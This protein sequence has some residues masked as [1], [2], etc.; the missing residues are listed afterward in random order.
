MKRIVFL[1]HWSK[2]RGGAEYSLLDI[3]AAMQG[4]AELFLIT[5]EEGGVTDKAR[6]LS[7]ECY[8]IPCRLSQTAIQREHILRHSIQSVFQLV[9]FLA[10]IMKVYRRVKKIDPDII[11]ANVPKSHITLFALQKMGISCTAVFH[12]REIFKQSSLPFRLYSLLFRKNQS[13][14]I[15]ISQAV[16]NHLPLRLKECADV[17]YN[18][19]FVPQRIRQVSKQHST[20]LLYLGRIVP[21]KG[22][23]L[24][25]DVCRL[26]R[27][28]FPHHSITM[29]LVGDTLYWTQKY[30]DH[31]Q[32]KIVEYN[33]T[34]I[35]AL[36]PHTET[37]ESVFR[38]H[39]LFTIASHEEPFGRVVA[40]AQAFGLPVVAFDSGGIAEIVAH[41][42]S[43]YCIPYGDTSAFSD[44]VGILIND[45]GRVDEMGKE[46]HRR[47]AR[48][49]NRDIQMPRI[50][51]HILLSK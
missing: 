24:L 45:P 31:L 6:G 28:R 17:I 5:S 12:I 27:D 44:A 33:L 15:A 8:S 32:E 26:L 34:G 41:E 3:L 40:E 2:Y 37:P 4:R 21:W 14:V 29:S 36:Y 48:Y 20:R 39:T 42:Q 47:A 19:V 16:K 13:R 9:S 38:S 11:H 25:I 51:E 22:C 23:T 30:R 35:C 46:G 7:V 1:N 10:F 50:A 18:G 43:G 49:F